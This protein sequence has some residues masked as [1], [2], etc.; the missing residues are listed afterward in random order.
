MDILSFFLLLLFIVIVS[1]VFHQRTT[2]PLPPGP[3]GSFF[4]GIKDHLPS[5]EPW[6]AYAAWSDDYQ[7]MSSLP[8]PPL[9]SHPAHPGPI[10]SFKIHHTRTIIL[11]TPR[12][13]HNLL[14]LRAEIYSD[15][16][17]ARMYHD[18]CARGKSVFN[19]SSRSPRHKIYRRL[20]AD[21]L[22]VRGRAERWDV[23]ESEIGILVDGLKTSPERYEA[24]IRRY[25]TLVFV[26][27]D[28]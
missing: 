10:V 16:P 14:S 12:A 6:K 3:V 4:T 2:L 13:V 15:R 1:R 24:H 22:G 7:S 23:M 9:D 17:Y 26:L 20:L 25:V 19:V 28:S 21:D 8:S 5:S 18:I 11:N 27:S